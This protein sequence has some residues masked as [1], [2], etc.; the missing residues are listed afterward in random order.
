MVNIEYEGLHVICS[1]CGR[2]GRVTRNCPVQKE[3]P[4]V[5][6][7]TVGKEAGVTE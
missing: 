4:V 2:Y 5:E 3:V 6:M 7:A 1:S